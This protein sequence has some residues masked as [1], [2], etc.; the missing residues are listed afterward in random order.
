MD[1][2]TKS[3]FFNCLSCQKL[4]WV[5]KRIKLNNDYSLGDDFLLYERKTVNRRAWE[6]FSNAVDVKGKDKEALAQKTR[7]FMEDPKINCIGNASFISDNFYTHIDFIK[8]AKYGWDFI[9]I[10]LGKVAKH[11]YICDMA[12]KAMILVK[13]GIEINS[14]SLKLIN[15]KYRVGHKTSE[16]FKSIDIT[17]KVDPLAV[18]YILEYDRVRLAVSDEHPAPEPVFG[19]KCR[20]C[21]LFEEC[22]GQKIPHPIFHLPRLGIESIDEFLE[23]KIYSVCDIPDDFA[24]TPHQ[25]IVKKCIKTDEIYI[26][27]TLKEI[28]EAIPTPYYYLDFESITTVLPIYDGL[29]PHTQILTQFSIHKCS[30]INEIVEH[31]EYI[32][33]PK[34]NDQKAIAE[35]LIEC[36]G[37]EGAIITYSPSEKFSLL[38]LAQTYGDISQPLLKLVDRI[39]DFEYLIKSNYYNKASK[40]YSSIKVMLPILVKDMDY[41]FLEISLG[42]DAA[43]AFAFMALGVYDEKKCGEVRQNL[44]NY[45]KQDTLAMVKIHKALFDIAN[46]AG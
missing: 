27:P 12:Y 20:N 43:A 35:K 30:S 4:G 37:D 40:G 36:L 5:S 33:D 15:G 42:R 45:C 39:V 11:K 44:L 19:K 24:L 26:S 32:A 17:H 9:D 38:K 34:V 7:Q 10:K 1:Y 2:I 23:K 14:F 22:W 46:Q 41:D 18:D 29:A 6:L 25:N 16:L 28:I 3:I 8:R 31:C 21:S 13:L